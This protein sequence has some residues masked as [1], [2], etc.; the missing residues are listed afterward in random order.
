MWLE[1]TWE[2]GLELT[3]TRHWDGFGPSPCKPVLGWGQQT[4]WTLGHT[5]LVTGSQVWG[6][7]FD[8]WYPKKGINNIWTK[9]A[10]SNCSSLPNTAAKMPGTDPWFLPPI[11]SGSTKHRLYWDSRACAC[12]S[13]SPSQE[14]MIRV[15]EDLTQAPHWEHALPTSLTGRLPQFI[16]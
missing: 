13:P 14:T 3:A 9:E 6:P 12:L 15:N 10:G 2:V 5:V 11:F 4:Q 16:H 8:P 1:P 7:G